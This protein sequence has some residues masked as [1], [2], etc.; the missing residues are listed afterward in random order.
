MNVVI[1][2]STS[3]GIKRFHLVKIISATIIERLTTNKTA[4]I[5]RNQ[6]SGVWYCDVKG[7]IMLIT[8]SNKLM[9]P[10]IVETPIR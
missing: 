10:K 6:R 8:C 4:I 7:D 3:C 5:N 9:V 2:V 1:K